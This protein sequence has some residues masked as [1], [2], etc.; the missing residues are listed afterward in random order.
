M[1]FGI[2]LFVNFTFVKIYDIFIKVSNYEYRKMVK[3]E[4][5]FAKR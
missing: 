3:A 5:N 2:F 1:C 4:H